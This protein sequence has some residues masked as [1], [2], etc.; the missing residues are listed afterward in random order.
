MLQNIRGQKRK[1]L[2]VLFKL[3]VK[4]NPTACFISSVGPGNGGG[5]G[6]SLFSS[7]LKRINGKPVSSSLFKNLYNLYKP[8]SVTPLGLKSGKN[9]L[10][11]LK[12]KNSGNYPLS[13]KTLAS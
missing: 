8:V 3:S 2:S 11:I 9:I 12:L 10:G 4:T 13:L 6:S 5:G 1:N 7:F